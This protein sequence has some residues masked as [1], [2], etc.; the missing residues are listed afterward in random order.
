MFALELRRGR[1][2]AQ[3]AIVQLVARFGGLNEITTVP[4]FRASRASGNH[5]A[6]QT[7]RMKDIAWRNWPAS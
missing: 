6:S 3:S 7:I 2:R 1:L 5:L 4:L